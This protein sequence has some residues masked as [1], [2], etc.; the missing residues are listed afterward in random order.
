MPE[1]VVRSKRSAERELLRLPDEVQ[2]RFIA[3]MRQLRD[4]SEFPPAGLDIVRLRGT[5]D[6]WRLRIGS[7]R[8]FF[9]LAAGEAVFTRF[10]HRSNVYS[11]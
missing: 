6:G 1:L 8:A 5:R 7:Y 3:A 9:F 10:G 11:P 2:D 4:S